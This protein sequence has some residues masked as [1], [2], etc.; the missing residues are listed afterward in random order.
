MALLVLGSTTYRHIGRHYRHNRR[1]S[2]LQHT[3]H[4]ITRWSVELT[5]HLH[6][7]G[8]MNCKLVSV[9]RNVLSL[10]FCNLMVSVRTCAYD[11]A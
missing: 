8:T 10:P 6:W 4:A 7:C 3:S 1:R 11:E 9:K 2:R 5:D